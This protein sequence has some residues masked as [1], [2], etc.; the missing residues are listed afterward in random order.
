MAFKPPSLS[1]S[2]LNISVNPL[3]LKNAQI[4]I[5]IRIS[6]QRPPKRIENSYTFADP[7]WEFN[8]IRNTESQNSLSN[9]FNSLD[10]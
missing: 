5:H 9:I 8:E 4:R 10:R 6:V 3:L 2:L 1:F 7:S